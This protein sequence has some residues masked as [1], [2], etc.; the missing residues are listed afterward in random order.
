M[1]GKHPNGDQT[2]NAG[3]TDKAILASELTYR[4]LFE[5]AQDGI[6]IL[7]VDSGRITD[8]NPFLTNLLGF[9]HTEMV[10]QTV[11]ELSPFKDIWQNK[12]V[13]EQL[14]KDG[15]VRY[16]NLPL[17]TRHGRHIAV[18][19][20]SNVYEA[21][22][23]KVIQCNIRDITERKQAEER[24]RALNAELAR[25]A[26]QTRLLEA[27]FI[28]A[29]KMEVVGQL[30][31]GVAHDFN[32][33][34]AVIIGY[35]NLI[36]SELGPD[37]PLRTYAEE[38]QHAADRAV[39][40]TR[41]LLIFSR[42]QTVQPAVLDLNTVVKDLDKMLLR[43]IDEHIELTVEP[44]KQIGHVNADAG[45]IGQVLMNLVVN[46]RDAMPN[47]GR[48]TITTGNVTL[49]EKQA[50]ALPGAKPGDY[51]MISVSDTGTGMTDD[52]KAHL[53]EAFF[54]T[55]PSGKGT[56]LGLATCQTIVKQSGG[57]IEVHSELGKGTTFKIY[58]PRVKPPLESD[59]H[60]IKAGPVPR[61]TETVLVVEDEP[62][63]RHLAA[64]L[65]E[66]QGY[67]VLR[68]AN[69]QDALHV[70]REH[71]GS[72]IRLVITDIVMPLMGGKVMAE[73]LKTTYPDLKIL[74]TSGYT[75]EV[76]AQTGTPDAGM[77]FLAKPYT[78]ATLGRKVREM[79]DKSA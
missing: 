60:F 47:G 16:E 62:A 66:A 29:Q 41:Q 51:V 73:W 48:L 43:L 46:A 57:C 6:L 5:A 25:H 22:D 54:T 34:L 18:E 58:F 3:R 37:S 77:Q 13:L 71:Q 21:G 27:Q 52:V 69:G 39:G 14:Q 26:D 68:A 15:Y 7:D 20:V 1:R 59:T 10:G 53:F 40:L 45:Y 44:N 2:G 31:G 36:T 8:V 35:C 17:E 28:E 61:G 12:I 67:T 33:I 76:I 42:K 55:K 23:K 63:V 9:S 72:P 70:V 38:I 49:D 65:L 75:E 50:G 11:G 32:N 4:R 56:G 78:P 64:E 79:L 19:F 24:L 30:A 74:F